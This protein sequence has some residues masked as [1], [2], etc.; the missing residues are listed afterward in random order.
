VIQRVPEPARRFFLTDKGPHFV[1][2][3]GLYPC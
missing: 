2:F 1:Y 3:G